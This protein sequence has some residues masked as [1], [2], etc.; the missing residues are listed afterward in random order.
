MRIT[1]R[2]LKTII[3]ESVSAVR[4]VRLTESEILQAE[5]DQILQRHELW[6]RTNG[7]K[8]AQADLQGTDLSYANLS[9]ADLQGANLLDAYLNSAN[10]QGANLLDA[11]LGFTSLFRANLQGAELHRA[12]LQGADLSYANLQGA[13]L[14]DANLQDTKFSPDAVQYL[15][16]YSQWSRWKNEV[17][18]SDWSTGN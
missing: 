14:L 5:L 6:F 13:N 8:G 12:D 18:I 10:L 1:K 15:Q 16:Q 3:R 11:N 9:Y 7:K 4:R 17:V 2:Q